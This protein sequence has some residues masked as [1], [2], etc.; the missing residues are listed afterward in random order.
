MDVFTNFAHSSND[1][2]G[3]KFQ[4]HTVLSL[5]V[6]DLFAILI[7]VSLVQIHYLH[8]RI[9]RS[10]CNKLE[11]RHIGDLSICNTCHLVPAVAP[12]DSAT[13]EDPGV[14]VAHSPLKR[15]LSPQEILHT[16]GLEAHHSVAIDPQKFLV[17]CPAIVYEL[18][19]R[20]CYHY[21]ILT[22]EAKP[23]Q[24]THFSGNDHLS[25]HLFVLHFTYVLFSI[26]GMCCVQERLASLFYLPRS[27]IS[28]LFEAFSIR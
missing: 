6:E 27:T 10:K 25:S 28:E 9:A 1:I 24:A 19:Q 15:C 7:A 21:E 2:K 18:D 8:V 5:K 14:H 16:F 13:D 4:P 22:S 17:L 12:E 20:S 3:M 26:L 11:L 23:R